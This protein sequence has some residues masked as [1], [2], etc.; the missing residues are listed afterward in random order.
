VPLFNYALA[1]ALQLRKTSVR[2][3]EQP[4]DYSLRRLGCLLR[5]SLGWPAVRQFTSVSRETSVSPGGTEKSCYKPQP[6]WPAILTNVHFIPSWC[7]LAAFEHV[8]VPSRAYGAEGHAVSSLFAWS[9]VAGVRPH[10]NGGVRVCLRPCLTSTLQG[11][12]C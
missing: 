3:A 9:G 10:S 2:A 12:V 11:S 5:D 7:S 1:F 4:Q 6:V 8:K